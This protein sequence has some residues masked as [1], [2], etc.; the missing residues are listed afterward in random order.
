M[1]KVS[2]LGNVGK[3]NRG[4]DERGMEKKKEDFLPDK[5]GDV[6]DIT[7][8]KTLMEMVFTNKNNRG[9]LILIWTLNGP[10]V[11]RI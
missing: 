3:V 1:D 6:T 2:A 9:P 4:F 5:A 10:I 7:S 11:P 8:Y